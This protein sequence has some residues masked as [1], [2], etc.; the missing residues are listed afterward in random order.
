MLEYLNS[1][2]SSSRKC[3]VNLMAA[4]SILNIVVMNFGNQIIDRVTSDV[5]ILLRK[6]KA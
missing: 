3:D 4:V 1:S 2:L 5:S 6:T